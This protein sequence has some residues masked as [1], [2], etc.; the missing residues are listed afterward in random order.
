MGPQQNPKDY[1]NYLKM[2]KK[3][4]LWTFG[5]GTLVFIVFHFFRGDITKLI[6]IF[7]LGVFGLFNI[8]VLIFLFI[9][10]LVN[11][12]SKS[13]LIPILKSILV[14]LINVPIGLLYLQLLFKNIF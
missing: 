14:L 8:A 10:F 1:S 6:G 11:A 5:L 4:A 7:Y 2:A 9:M 13:K 3:L 12:K